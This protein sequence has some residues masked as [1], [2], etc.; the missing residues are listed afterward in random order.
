MSTM[1]RFFRDDIDDPDHFTV[2]LERVPG[3]ESRGRSVDVK[4]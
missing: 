2:T 3:R 1:I 4:H